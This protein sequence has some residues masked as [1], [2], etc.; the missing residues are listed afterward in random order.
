MVLL[1]Q[2]RYIEWMVWDGEKLHPKWDKVVGV[3]LYDHTGQD[4]TTTAY[5]DASENMNMAPLP[6][7]KALVVSM[8]ALL[9]K[10]VL[11]YMVDYPTPQVPGTD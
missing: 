7:N 8:S 10:T 5:M 2:Y 4:Q 9:K 1:L 11:K 6:E 3:E